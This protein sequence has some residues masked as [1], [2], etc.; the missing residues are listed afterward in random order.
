MCSSDLRTLLSL[1]RL[2]GER[3]T[4]SG[5]ETLLACQPLQQ[6]F[7]LQPREVVRLQGVLQRAGFRWGL[8][9]PAR[10][11]DPVHSLSWTIT[12]GSA[13]A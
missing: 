13:N 3:L 1:L 9:G 5:L 8:D 10:G 6:H 7:E 11:G 2:G 12:V 4:A